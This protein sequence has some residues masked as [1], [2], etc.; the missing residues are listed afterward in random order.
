MKCEE[1]CRLISEY[2]D[3]ELDEELH[4]AISRHLAECR[5]CTVFLHTIEETLHFS[6][7]IYKVKK[8]PLKVINRVYCEIRIKYRENRKK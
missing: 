7:E 2:L 3:N 4:E 6:R 1:I 8:V 5:K